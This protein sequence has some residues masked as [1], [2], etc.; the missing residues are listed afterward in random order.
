[1]KHCPYLTKIPEELR[2]KGFTENVVIE[3]SLQDFNSRLENN[4]DITPEERVLLRECRRR[5][6]NRKAA[7]LSRNRSTGGERGQA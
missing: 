2:S 1:M 4:Q 3:S 5:G 6:K 7:Y